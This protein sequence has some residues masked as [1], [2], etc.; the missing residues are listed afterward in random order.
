MSIGSRPI[1]EFPP[2]HVHQ[3]EPLRK[4]CSH[5]SHQYEFPTRPLP[6]LLLGSYRTRPSHQARKQ[7]LIFKKSFLPLWNM[8]KST[9]PP[10]SSPELTPRHSVDSPGGMEHVLRDISFFEDAP[11]SINSSTRS[12]SSTIH[13][14]LSR[15]MSDPIN[16]KHHVTYVRPLI[17]SKTIQ[18]SDIAFL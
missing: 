15:T 4:K 13:S 12:R 2:P 10:T 14:T 17:P 5:R 6:S 8:E 16:K 1:Q 3:Q 9:L 11:Y 18:S 7:K